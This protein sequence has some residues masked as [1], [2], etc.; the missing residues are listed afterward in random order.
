[1]KGST[2]LALFLIAAGVVLV[3]TGLRNR[4]AQFKQVTSK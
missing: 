2:F 4:A 1:M 3:A